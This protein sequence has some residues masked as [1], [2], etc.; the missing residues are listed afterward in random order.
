M[1]AKDEELHDSLE[2]AVNERA[3]EDKVVKKEDGAK[4]SDALEA[5]LITV[6][7]DVIE[8]RSLFLFHRN[9]FINMVPMMI[10]RSRM[11]SMPIAIHLKFFH[12]IL[13]AKSFA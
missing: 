5:A 12:H 1:E 9:S 11:Q 2:D 6:S 4:E 13:F 3:D 7:H 8:S 10:M